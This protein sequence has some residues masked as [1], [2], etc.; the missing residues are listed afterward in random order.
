MTMICLLNRTTNPAL[1]Q[2]YWAG[3]AKLYSHFFFKF[4]G[5]N[6]KNMFFFTGLH[7]ITAI[8]VIIATP[9]TGP[10]LMPTQEN[11]SPLHTTLP[12][13]TLATIKPCLS[14]NPLTFP[15]FLE[16]H[17]NFKIPNFNK[18]FLL[19]PD[20]NKIL[21]DSSPGKNKITIDSFPVKNRLILLSPGNKSK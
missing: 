17:S 19:S 6:K 8:P 11:P 21:V 16:R 12:C 13:H 2:Q 5:Y 18:I 15:S 14:N 3:W 20:K 9:I 4:S 10:Q 7:T 1:I